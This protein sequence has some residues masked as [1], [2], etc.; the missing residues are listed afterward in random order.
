MTRHWH[1]GTKIALTYTLFATGTLTMVGIA[2]SQRTDLVTPDYYARAL[3]Q[4]ERMAALANTAALGAA[5]AIT[6]TD[7]VV[8]VQWP[9]QPESGSLVLYRPSN[10]DADR[11]LPLAATVV[12]AGAE[13]QV[14]LT[15]LMPGSW[16]AQ[17][18][19]TW[20][21]RPYYAERDLIVR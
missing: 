15:G 5:F 13:Q 3:K 2:V 10:A 6:Q 18:T 4:D 1:W 17:V 7:D 20:Q 19:W 8:R 11:T 12:A 16:R 21:G 14:P 9:H